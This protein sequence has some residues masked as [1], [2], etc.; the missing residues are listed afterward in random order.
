MD[1][2]TLLE[3]GRWTCRKIKIAGGDC[4]AHP[5][6]IVFAQIVAVERQF[7]GAAEILDPPK[8]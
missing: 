1:G 5:E 8:E 7:V 2:K 3:N 4:A 6:I